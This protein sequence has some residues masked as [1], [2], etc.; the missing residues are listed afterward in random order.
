[1]RTEGGANQTQLF[2]QKAATLAL[3]EVCSDRRGIVVWQ[4][5]VEVGAEP[6]LGVLAV[7]ECCRAREE[8]L[9]QCPDKQQNVCPWGD[10][11][12]GLALGC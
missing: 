2:E 5:A 3:C 10:R 1:M 6:G 8:G 7:H 4:L 11:F 9:R 12:C